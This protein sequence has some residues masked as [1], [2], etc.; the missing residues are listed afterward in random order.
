MICGHVGSGDVLKLFLF[1]CAKL[2]LSL[3]CARIFYFFSYKLVLMQPLL[4]CSMERHKNG[5]GSNNLRD[6][7]TCRA[8]C[9]YVLRHQVALRSR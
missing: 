5:M 3:D 7:Q 4:E 2:A 1:L 8:W 6:F 9:L